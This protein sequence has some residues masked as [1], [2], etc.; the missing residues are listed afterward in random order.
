MTATPHRGDPA[1]FR[2]LDL[3]KPGFFATDEMLAESIERKDNPLF[4]RRLK[5]DLTSFDKTPLFPPRK[6]ITVKY[7]LG[8]EVKILAPT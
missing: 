4:L 5:E 8:D 6:V 3:L 2:L 1:N 7:P